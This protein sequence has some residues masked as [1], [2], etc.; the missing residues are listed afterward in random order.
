MKNIPLLFFI[1]LL[2]L[3][4]GP[5][6]SEYEK[7]INAFFVKRNA[8]LKAPRAYLRVNGLF[9]LDEHKT[10]SF[11]KGESADFIFPDS[12]LPDIAGTVSRSVKQISFTLNDKIP[13]YFNGEPFSEGIIYDEKSLGFITIGNS[14]FT[15][16]KRGDLLG[17]RLF[18][19]N[20]DQ[21]DAFSGAERFP[22]NSAFRVKAK[23]IKDTNSDSIQIM[24]V[25]GQLSNFPSPGLLEFSINGE[26]FRL[27]PQFDGD[28][29]FLVFGDKSN[30][31]QTYQGGRFLYISPINE[32]GETFID[33]NKSENPPCAY[34]DFTTCPL[35]PA[36]NKLPIAIE[37]GEK[38]WKK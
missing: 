26:S 34:N 28:E 7:E 8:E 6:Q 25:L 9:W 16:I 12:S 22:I 3:G 14:E 37:A 23:L 29:Y 2:L 19:I 13:A 1:I 36:Q 31:T 17:I 15:I 20:N 10:Y 4:C 11:G 35:P 5:K 21:I 30:K 33:F 18:Q 32:Q 24:N 38:R 27:Q